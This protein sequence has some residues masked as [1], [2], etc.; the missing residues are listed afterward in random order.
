MKK[1]SVLVLSATLFVLLGCARI[2]PLQKQR[3]S[4]SRTDMFVSAH[5]DALGGNNSIRE[6]ILKQYE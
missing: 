3:I 5:Y 4:S 1:L 6:E 2:T